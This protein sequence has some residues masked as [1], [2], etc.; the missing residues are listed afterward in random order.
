MVKRFL[1]AWMFAAL[2]VGC[3][4]R[5]GTGGVQEEPHGGVDVQEGGGVQG[6]DGAEEGPSAQGGDGTQGEPRG[7]EIG[8]PDPVVPPGGPVL[9]ARLRCFTNE[10]WGVKICYD[11]SLSLQPDANGDS[12]HFASMEDP[13]IFGDVTF[14]RLTDVDLGALDHRNE[15]RGGLIEVD[16]YY[17][18]GGVF[19]H[20]HRVTPADKA[21]IRVWPPAVRFTGPP[22]GLPRP[23]PPST[24][25]APPSLTREPK[26]VEERAD[27][28]IH[29]PP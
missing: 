17:V 7:I 8:S 27:P 15:P 20:L 29:S 24:P 4:G 25:S 1:I 12:A 18:Q 22:T 23:R 14:R 21:M 2:V 13:E 6:G 19:I 26:T 3:S 10:T 5:I 9:D 28:P 16:E 11:R